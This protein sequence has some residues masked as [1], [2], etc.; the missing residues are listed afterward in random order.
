MVEKK[1]LACWEISHCKQSEECPA[2]ANPNK[3]CWEIAAEMPDYRSAFNICNDCLVYLAKKD[4]SS[5][6]EE[7]LMAI[8]ASKGVCMLPSNCPQRI[9]FDGSG[10]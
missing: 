1:D 5:L 9:A 3:P 10:R 6:P 2:R 7:E 8:L 4:N